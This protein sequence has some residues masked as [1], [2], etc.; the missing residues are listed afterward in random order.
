MG[1]LR[2]HLSSLAVVVKLYYDFRTSRV[3]S[4]HSVAFHPDFR[5]A[6][7]RA[8]LSTTFTASNTLKE[9]QASCLR[10]SHREVTRHCPLFFVAFQ[11][12]S[13]FC[14]LSEGV[15]LQEAVS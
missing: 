14:G 6:S 7:D 2:L 4:Y 10:L 13:N 1:D 15:S 11:V 5:L 12:R 9:S 3:S 8:R